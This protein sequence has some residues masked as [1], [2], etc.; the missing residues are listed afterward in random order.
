VR[1][2]DCTFLGGR[3]SA[4]LTVDRGEAAEVLLAVVAATGTFCT[5]R[6]RGNL[7]ARSRSPRSTMSL[8]VLV[9]TAGRPARIFDGPGMKARAFRRLPRATA[10]HPAS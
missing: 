6:D 10:D 1:P 2:V 8:L 7:D 5:R 3:A 4:G 9:V